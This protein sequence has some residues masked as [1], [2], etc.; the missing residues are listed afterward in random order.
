LPTASRAEIPLRRLSTPDEIA[1]A[2]EYLATA[3]NATG[4][5]MNVDGGLVMD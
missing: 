5:S 4:Q 1:A 3:A 2:V